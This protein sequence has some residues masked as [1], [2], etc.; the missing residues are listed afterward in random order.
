MNQLLHIDEFRDILS[1]Y[2]LSD[3]AK[4]VLQDL[5]LVLMVGP[6]SSGRN[7]II[8]ELVKTGHY[9]FIV[10]DT[11]RKPRSNDG[12]MEQSGVEYWFRS[13]EEMLADLRQGMFLEAAIIHNQQVS[14]MS[15]RELAKARE[16][17]KIA[18][19]EVE[20]AGAGNTYIAKPDTIIIFS[21]PPGFDT[22]MQRLQNRGKLPNDEIQRRLESACEEF[23]AALTHEYYHFVINDKIDETVA[24][25]EAMAQRGEFNAE[26][27]RVAREMVK[28]LY[29]KTK[30]Y[31]LVN[32]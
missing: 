5:R 13:E 23:E 24:T 21:V 30:D 32:Y 3:E 4:A 14:G 20:I 28:D 16:T 15:I 11:T 22:W 12:V 17:H 26:Q 19:D 18:I 27:E 29:R 9:H 2:R 8:R 31:L 7:T 6:T 25:I 10:S 1:H